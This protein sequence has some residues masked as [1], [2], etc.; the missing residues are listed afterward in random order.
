MAEK[1]QFNFQIPT[2]IE[3]GI[4]TIETIGTHTKGQGIKKPM[5]VTDKT[6]GKSEDSLA[7]LT[8]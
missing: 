8:T 7:Q 6:I 4:G 1:L 5:L 2:M 3:F